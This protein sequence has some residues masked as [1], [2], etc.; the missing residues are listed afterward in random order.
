MI[1]R[2]LWSL[3]A[4]L[5]WTGL[6]LAQVA[7]EIPVP[8]YAVWE[9]KA[10]Q[11]ETGLA[12]GRTPSSALERYR[13]DVAEWR[14]R[15]AAARGLNKPRID[16][17]QSQIAA[18]G[19]PPENGQEVP[20][21]AE[22]RA[23]LTRQLAQL[24]E[25]VI[26]AEEAYKR[27]D[28]LVGEID[29]TLRAR[30]ADRLF[31]LGQTPL[32]PALWPDALSDLRASL[33][34][35]GGEITASF[36]QGQVRGALRENGVVLL[37]ALVLGLVLLS[38]GKHWV[39]WA[40]EALSIRTLRGSGVWDVL[41]SVGLILLP[42]IGVTALSIALVELDLFGVRGNAIMEQAPYWA[43]VLHGNYWMAG[44]VFDADA[45]RALLPLSETGRARAH[46]IALWLAAFLVLRDVLWTIADAGFYT[47]ATRAVLEFPLILVTSLFLYRLAVSFSKEAVRPEESAQGDFRVTLLRGLG[48]ILKLVAVASPVLAGIGYYAL[49]IALIYPTVYT[50]AVMGLVLVSQ[51]FLSDLYRLVMRQ[52]DDAADGLVSVLAGFILILGALPFV[53]LIWGARDTDLTEIWARFL[54]GFQVGTTRISPT[55]FLVFA[56]LFVVGYL[57]TRLV[58]GALRSSVLPKTRLDIGGQNAIVSGVGYIGIFLAALVAIT[59]TGL[60]L[61]NLAIVAGALS[62]GVGFGLQTIV[63]NF[64]SGIILLIERPVSEGDWIQ[65]GGYEGTVRA[66]SVRSTR[67]ETFDRADVILPNSDLIS[68]AVTNLTRGNTLGRVIVPV[69]VSYA[70]DTRQVEEVL[71]R[72]ARDH[73]MVLMNPAPYVLFKGFGDSALDFEL[74]FILRDISASLGVRTEMNHRILAAFREEGIE[75]PFP[76]TDLWLRNPETLAA[77]G[78]QA[79]PVSEIEA[80][81]IAEAKVPKGE[82]SE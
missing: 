5:L 57:I 74:R 43:L 2:G 34:A 58:Q 54:N 27:A 3:T 8:D 41:I 76:Q 33:S 75:I 60:D 29:R 69:G 49:S 52:P 48:G 14:E 71:L 51:R 7:A 22:R 25:P 16:T 24:R 68:G 73:P 47:A 39:L 31:R 6:V 40:G 10:K 72:I 65:V 30:Q 70:S 35:L 56:A 59:A 62:V 32:N 79:A 11:V 23:E 21:I 81:E 67:I 17:L 61:S 80:R 37:G 77:G 45:G 66:I 20:E 64:V 78:P 12:G 82:G 18:L 1:R 26:G 50:L 9:Q 63:S 53:A 19:T 15:F 36:R 38:R 46:R 42:L 44:R 28:G 4:F 55:D 13:D